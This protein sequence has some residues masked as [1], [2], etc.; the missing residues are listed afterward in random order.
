VRQKRPHTEARRVPRWALT[1]PTGA[2]KSLVSALLTE[3]GAEVVDAD[4]LGHE[5]LARPE[6][7]AAIAAEIGA[8]YV[9]DGVVDRT[10]L[11]QRVFGDREALVRLNAITHPPLAEEAHRRLA[12]IVAAGR[13][14]LA[15]LEAAVYFLLPAP[16]PMDLTVAITA[17]VELRLERLVGDGLAPEVAQARIAAQQPLEPTF[18]RAAVILHNIGAREELAAAVDRLLAIHLEEQD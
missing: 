17:P 16:G 3:R 8:A 12:A 6:I 11:G 10:S 2:G 4:R 5:I 15:V 14:R 13:A 1:G 9:R 7:Q 18:E